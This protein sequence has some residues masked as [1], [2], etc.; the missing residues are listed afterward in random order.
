MTDRTRPTRRA[1]P[2]GLTAGAGL[3]LF[4]TVLILLAWQVRAGR[5]PALGVPRSPGLLAQTQPRRVLV[6]RII[7]RVIDEKVI[8]NDAAPAASAGVMVS[9]APSGGGPA[10]VNSAAPVVVQAAP[11]PAPAA[12][13]VVTRTS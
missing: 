2:P 12:A 3:A 5:D 7:R 8:E 4:A 9:A 1:L 6:K 13:P 11:A 10:V